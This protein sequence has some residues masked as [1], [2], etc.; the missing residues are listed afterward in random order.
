MTAQLPIDP[1]AYAKLIELLETLV[2]D[3]RR[4]REKIVETHALVFAI[5]PH[6]FGAPKHQE[7]WRKIQ[8]SLAGRVKNF[9][10]ER[11]P[12]DRL[13]I[14]NKT[15]AD[16]LGTIWGLFLELHELSRSSLPS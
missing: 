7:A 16:V 9:G 5:S 1:Y 10:S 2:C 14:R 11:I 6:D 13:T 8:R 12:D 15:L 3:V 4:A